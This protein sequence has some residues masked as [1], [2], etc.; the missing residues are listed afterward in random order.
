M[1]QAMSP[2]RQRHR[3]GHDGA[4]RPAGSVVDAG[5]TLL[6]TGEPGA[7]VTIRAA[8]GTLLGSG[9]VAPDGSFAA[10]LTPCRPMAR[11]SS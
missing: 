5:A 4:A 9:Q 11:P 8:D 7:T 1:R 3:A 2:P 6:G 10:T